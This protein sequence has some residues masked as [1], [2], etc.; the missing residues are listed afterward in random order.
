MINELAIK[1][2]FPSFLTL[3]NIK[4]TTT[5]V[6]SRF[7]KMLG[8]GGVLNNTFMHGMRQTISRH[9][10]MRHL[11]QQKGRENAD[12]ESLLLTVQASCD[13]IQTIEMSCLYFSIFLLLIFFSL[14]KLVFGLLLQVYVDC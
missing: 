14:F 13:Y 1:V 4:P 2:L 6:E 7:E 10:S 9:C 11:R 5:G 3:P 8:R 12:I